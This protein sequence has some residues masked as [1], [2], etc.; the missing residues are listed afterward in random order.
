M[1]QKIAK[2]AHC[3]VVVVFPMD[4]VG[5]VHLGG[6]PDQSWG[7]CSCPRQRCRK[8]HETSHQ[9]LPNSPKAPCLIVYFQIGDRSNEVSS[10]PIDGT[11]NEWDSDAGSL[12]SQHFTMNQ[13]SSWQWLSLYLMSLCPWQLHFN[14]PCI[15]ESLKKRPWQEIGQASAQRKWQ[16]SYV[17]VQAFKAILIWRIHSLHCWVALIL[18]LYAW[19]FRSKVQF[20]IILKVGHQN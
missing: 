12:T 5:L 11:L 1:F 7:D 17:T 2:I 13:N 15:D 3:V 20:E 10:R 19:G 6:R 9:H 18:N 4:L 8:L 14:D 16:T